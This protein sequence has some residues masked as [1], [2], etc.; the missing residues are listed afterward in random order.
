MKKIKWEEKNPEIR[1]NPVSN[2]VLKAKSYIWALLKQVYIAHFKYLL[3]YVFFIHTV[4]RSL[5]CFK[6]VLFKYL[7]ERFESKKFWFLSRTADQFWDI[8]ICRLLNRFK[9]YLNN[10]FVNKTGPRFREEAFNLKGVSWLF[11]TE[12]KSNGP[13]F[14]N[15]GNCFVVKTTLSLR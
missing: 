3:K 6:N 12:S 1:I 14:I 7:I 5:F 4:Q 13:Q 9:I 15:S 10:H 2:S 11:V 8:K